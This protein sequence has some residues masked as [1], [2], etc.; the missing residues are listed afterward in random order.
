[1]R[2][3]DFESCIEYI[4]IVKKLVGDEW[5]SQ[6]LE[7]VRARKPPANLERLTYVG[8]TRQFHPLALLIYLADK[9]IESSVVATQEMLRLSYLG[10]N[11]SV[12]K[13]VNT[14][15]LDRKIRD[16]TSADTRLSDSAAYEIEVAARYTE[17]GYPVEFMET[18]SEEGIATP[19]I[20]VGLGNRVEV[21]CKQK[22]RRSRRDIRN[23]QHFQLIV[24]KASEVMGY[25][26]LDYA[27]HIKT[28]DDLNEVDVEFIVARLHA[29]M[30]QG[31]QGRFEFRDRDI[32]I[33]LKI[34]LSRGQ[35]IEIRP[36]WM[37][38]ALSEEANYYVQAVESR[39][40]EDGKV[41]AR[42]I[43][44]IGFMSEVL[45]DRIR[46]VMKS[47][48]AA[49][50]QLSGKRPALVHVNAD[51]TAHMAETDLDRLDFLIRNVLKNN[52]RISGMVITAEFFV[53][54]IQGPVFGHSARAIRNEGA[55][56][57]LPSGFEMVGE[58]RR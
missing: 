31:K 7:K 27:V 17:K 55:R 53:D 12:L 11:L 22:E 28:H 26:G 8:S 3:V 16:L 54:S 19:D 20:L 56:Y 15:G 46:G 41:H 18:R 29:L 44:Q 9:H 4:E 52:S 10:K 50:G 43:R 39:T 45:P 13:N 33:A 23:D 58:K 21:E 38:C 5:L 34:L 14:K 2:L 30:E 32:Q 40:D 48:K 51:V 1:M 37:Q 47:V 25:C 35:E 36:E 57:P 24:R 49:R 42:H 6:E